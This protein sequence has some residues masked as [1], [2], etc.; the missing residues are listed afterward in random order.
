MN[1]IQTAD[2]EEIKEMKEKLEAIVKPT[3]GKM[4]ENEEAGEGAEEDDEHDEL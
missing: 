4:Y 3:I 2:A 1:S